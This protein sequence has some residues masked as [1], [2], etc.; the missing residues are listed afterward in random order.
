MREQEERGW[1][2]LKPLK[3]TRIPRRHIF[4]DAEARIKRT[5]ETSE[6]TWRLGVAVYVTMRKGGRIQE[7]VEVFREAENFWESVATFAKPGTRTVLWT[8]NLPYD[9]RISDAFSSLSKLGFECVAHNIAARGAWLEWRHDMATLLMVDS[10]AIFP[11][12]IAQ[13]GKWFGLGK[14]TMDYDSEDE[15]LW[16]ARCR[17]DV[18]ILKTAVLEYL[19]WLDDEDMGNWQITGSS[20]SLALFRRRFLTHNLTT[21][22]AP[23]ALAMER[24]AMWAGRCEAYWHGELSF[25][26]VHEWDFQNA[27]ASIARD[28]DVPMRLL[29]PMPA[30]YDVQSGLRNKHIALLADVTVSTTVPVVPASHGGRI[31]WPTGTFRTT[32]WDVEIEAALKAGAMVDVHSGWLYRKGPALKAWGTWLLEQLDA[33]DTSVPVWQKAIL[34]HH[35]RALIGRMA[36]T[37][38]SWQEFGIAPEAQVRAM[39]ITDLM[40]NETYDTM[41]IGRTIWRDGGRVEWYKSMP[42]ITGY[43][44][45]IARVRLWNVMRA[46]PERTVLYVDT[47][48]LI[49]TDSNLAVID[50]I[51][52]S[53]VGKGLRLK[54]S[55]DGFAIYGPRQLVTGS[56][57]RVSGLPTRASHVGRRKFSGEV[58]DSLGQSIRRGSASSVIVRNRQWKIEGVDHRRIG[59]TIGWTEPIHI[60]EEQT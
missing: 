60:S 31:V 52:R 44:Q 24:R 8:H 9:L 39:T 6:Q 30:T 53:D 56:K 20:Q 45:A 36:M 15:N 40:D 37:Y 12:T 22:D 42:M 51:A 38:R 32:L 58:W 59:D 48:S 11:T 19:Q 46:L 34:K 29:S 16:V 21:H 28:Y 13:I 49:S 26:T 1:Y 10:T 50:R 47:D 33:P 4:L 18:A 2:N 14:P 35:G 7:A 27:Y 17:A 57:V 54:R 41:Q 55:W 25:Q 43:I 3:G 23:D 5:G